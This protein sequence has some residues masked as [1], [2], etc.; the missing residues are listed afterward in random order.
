MSLHAF[1]VRTAE[2]FMADEATRRQEVILHRRN[3]RCP[4]HEVTIRPNEL[5]CW[6][7]GCTEEGVYDAPEVPKP[8]RP[9]LGPSGFQIVAER[10]AKRR[11][12]ETTPEDE[13]T[14][15]QQTP[16]LATSLDL[17]RG[18]VGTSKRAHQSAPTPVSPSLETTRT[19]AANTRDSGERPAEPST[20]ESVALPEPSAEE[21][22]PATA[23]LVH[24][25]RGGTLVRCTRQH[26]CAKSPDNEDLEVDPFPYID[27]SPNKT[28]RRM[29]WGVLLARPQA[30]LAH[31]W[32]H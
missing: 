11:R 15:L 28:F 24:K 17:A 3:R 25:A 14:R 13:S 30:S 16:N 9:P 29:S 8:E 20:R 7:E 10:G 12:S 5:H 21:A 27:A 22:A 26:M 6:M 23:T 32:T 19:E 1:G 4:A 2:P 18:A 31:M